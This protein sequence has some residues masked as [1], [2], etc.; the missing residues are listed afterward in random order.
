MDG[1]A[2]RYSEYFANRWTAAGNTVKDTT[3]K[4]AESVSGNKTATK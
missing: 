2:W 3:G 1:V 4:G